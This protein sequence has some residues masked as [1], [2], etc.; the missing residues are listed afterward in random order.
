MIAR[1]SEARYND[2]VYLSLKKFFFDPTCPRECDIRVCMQMGHPPML[3]AAAEKHGPLSVAILSPTEK[4]PNSHEIMYNVDTD[5]VIEET[6]AYLEDHW[7]KGSFPT[8]DRE[9][10]KQQFHKHI[11]PIAL[12]IPEKDCGG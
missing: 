4:A 1:M 9:A 8:K 2:L 3:A 12:E 7:I 6:L 5:N 10:I 11:V